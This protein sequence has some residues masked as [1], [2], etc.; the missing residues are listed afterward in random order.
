M[1]N[2]KEEPTL[3]LTVLETLERWPAARAVLVARGL[4]LCCGGVHPVGMAARAHGVDPEAL[5]AELR[6]AASDGRV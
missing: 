4:D 1:V 2:E 3:E 5:L 6:S